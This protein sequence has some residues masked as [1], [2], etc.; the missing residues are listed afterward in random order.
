MLSCLDEFDTVSKAFKLG[1]HDYI[2]K[3]ELE[4]ENLLAALDSV[5][6]AEGAGPAPIQGLR[7]PQRNFADLLHAGEGNDA[8]CVENAGVRERLEDL[9][10]ASGTLMLA[11][12]AFKHVYSGDFS[13]EEWPVDMDMCITLVDQQLAPDRIG[14]A[15]QDSPDRILVVLEGD[16]GFREKRMAFLSALQQELDTYFNR[17][18]LICKSAVH[19][20]TEIRAAYEEAASVLKD[21]GF[22]YH[23]SQILAHE[24]FAD[25]PARDRLEVPDP[26]SLLTDHDG[27]WRKDWERFFQDLEAHRPAPTQAAMAL[28]RYWEDLE[29]WAEKAFQWALGPI[30]DSFRVYENLRTID[31]SLVLGRW[32][33]AALEAVNGEARARHLSDRISGRI[34][35]LINERYRDRLTLASLAKTFHLNPNYICDLFKRDTGVNFI[36]YLNRVRVER[37]I[38]LLFSGE[39]TAEEVCFR[40]GFHNPSHFSRVFKKVTGSTITEYRTGNHRQPESTT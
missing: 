12:L 23:R 37:A 5:A 33:L 22:Y 34:I 29:S 24:R 26:K 15:F 27:S 40:V 7:S 36:D 1:I 39:L 21:F 35:Y 6:E 2:L 8:A 16:D 20:V 38:D 13:V 14:S 3:S 32:F 11:I 31:D 17:T 4:K 9:G 10:F 18:Y 30:G 28:L 25:H 19:P